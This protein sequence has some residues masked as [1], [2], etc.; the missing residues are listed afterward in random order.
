[1][2]SDAVLLHAVTSCESLTP[3]TAMMKQSL[4][5][6]P[7]VFTSLAFTPMT[8][9]QQNCTAETSNRILLLLQL[10]V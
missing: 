4:T 10:H 2:C 5:E 6:R 7:C 9:V 3:Y 1:M 8:T